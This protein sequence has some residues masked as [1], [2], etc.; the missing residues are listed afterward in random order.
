MFLK[1]VQNLSFEGGV[2]GG[3]CKLAPDWSRVITR[4]RNWPLISRE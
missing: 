4:A 2:N 1:K 3:Q